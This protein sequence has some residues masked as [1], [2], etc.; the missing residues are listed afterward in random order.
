[1]TNSRIVAI[2]GASAGI[3]RATALRLA[4]DG[5]S[6]AI[7]ARRAALLDRVVKEIEAA[8]GLEAGR[9]LDIQVLDHLVIGKSAHVSLKTRGLG[10]E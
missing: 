2:T 1:M 4:R 8:G 7:C 9:L 10:F 6:L 3:G 5:G